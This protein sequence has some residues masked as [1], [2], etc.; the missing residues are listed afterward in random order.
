LSPSAANVEKG[1]ATIGLGSY[2]RVQV[3]DRFE[4]SSK[5]EAWRIDVTQ[6]SPRYSEG[7][8]TLLS[9]E[10]GAPGSGPAERDVILADWP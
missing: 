6:V 2:H 9:R 10:D 7:K 3:G 5:T 1:T 4:I 8:L